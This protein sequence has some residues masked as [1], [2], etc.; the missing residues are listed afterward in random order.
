M[1]FCFTVHF[2]LLKTN[3]YVTLLATVS[4]TSPKHETLREFIEV[5]DNLFLKSQSISNKE[6]KFIPPK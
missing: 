6:P 2:V 4:M 1:L 3:Y 5:E